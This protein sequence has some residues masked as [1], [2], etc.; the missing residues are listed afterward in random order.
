MIS[1]IAAIGKNRELGFGG[2]LPWYLPDDLKRFKNITRGHTVIMGRK[3][4]ES[5]PGVLPSRRNIVITRDKA[6][7]H[8]GVEVV[9][10]IEK[11]LELVK[12]D[13]EPFV[14]G[15]GEIFKQALPYADKMY[16]THVEAELRAD[17]FFPEFNMNEWNLVSEDPRPKDARHLYDF[18]FKV[19]QRKA[20]FKDLLRFLSG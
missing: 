16:L 3:T 12:A 15:G 13:P 11:A 4:L 6:Y 10:S 1:I 20:N 9:G 18:N 2:K 17:S 8:E 5:L 14:I 7:K 19:Y